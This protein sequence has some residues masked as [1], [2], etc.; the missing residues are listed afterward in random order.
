MKRH[1]VEYIQKTITF[2]L[3]EEDKKKEELS[4]KSK[5]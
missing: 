3:G 1:S 5:K 4:P 2:Q